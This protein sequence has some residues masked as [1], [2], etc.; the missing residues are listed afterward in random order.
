MYAFRAILF[1]TSNVSGGVKFAIAGTATAT[2]FIARALVDDTSALKVVGTARTTTLGATIGDI[3]AVTVANVIIEGTIVVNAGGT[4]T[5]QF[6]QNASN[7]NA[8][9]VLTNSYFQLI[10][11]GS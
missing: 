11:I 4:L 2:S 7:V 10:S 9:T 6:A 5:V 1:T 3:T 8:S